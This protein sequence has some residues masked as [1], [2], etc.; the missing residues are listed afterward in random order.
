MKTHISLSICL[1]QYVQNMISS[2]RRHKLRRTHVN[3]VQQ[4]TVCFSGAIEIEPFKRKFHI[5]GTKIVERATYK[6]CQKMTIDSLYDRVMLFR[7]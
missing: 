5:H 3:K 7:K 2:L 6:I 4:K 1:F